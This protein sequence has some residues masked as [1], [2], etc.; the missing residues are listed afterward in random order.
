MLRTNDAGRLRA[1]DVGTKV[2]LAG[3]VARR[4]DH[5][6][7]AFIDLRDAT[8]S[9]Q[10]VISDEKVAGELRAE[11]CILVT[12]IVRKRPAGNENPNSPTGEIE[13]PVDEIEILSEAAPLPFPVDSGERVN[14]SE[15]VRLKYRYLD[16]RR[17]EPARAFTFTF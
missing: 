7:V 3:W 2:T 4:R 11:W 17:E 12:G 1:G 9:I 5:G 13:I 14:V 16:L 6:G 15:E 10:V 8:G